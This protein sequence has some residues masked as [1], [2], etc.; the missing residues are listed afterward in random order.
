VG[1]TQPPVQF[2]LGGISQGIKR[3][4]READHTP[5]SSDK[6]NNTWSLFT[7]VASF[8][9]APNHNSATFVTHHFD[10]E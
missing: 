1:L 7:H 5:P 4:E 10:L 2:V 9:M 8:S 6:V 3:L